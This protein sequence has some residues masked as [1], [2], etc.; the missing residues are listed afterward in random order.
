MSRRKVAED[1]QYDWCFVFNVKKEDSK[2]LPTVKILKKIVQRLQVSGLEVMVFYS[3]AGDKVFCKVGAKSER[4]KSEA[5]RIDYKLRLDPRALRD[6][7]ENPDS[8]SGR[9]PIILPRPPKKKGWFKH[10]NLDA[11]EYIYGK[12]D[13][14]AKQY[15]YVHYSIPG[16]DI[17]HNSIFRQTDR[18]KL[19][20]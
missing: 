15:L 1:I 14:E 18:I 5:D 13:S 20:R 9:K 8:E 17:A 2:K 6:E 4:L 11:Y 19:V 3:L 16:T 7:A 10:R 12:Y